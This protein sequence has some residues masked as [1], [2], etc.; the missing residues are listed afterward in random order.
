MKS[1]TLIVMSV[2]CYMASG[3]GCYTWA[4][5]L[6]S[7]LEDISISS[8]AQSTI[9]KKNDTKNIPC[10]NKASDTTCQDPTHDSVNSNAYEATNLQQSILNGTTQNVTVNGTQVDQAPQTSIS[11]S[12]F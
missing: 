6:D 8:E 4:E 1:S 5:D 3:V 9:P 10:T 11:I 2:L 7:A 12:G